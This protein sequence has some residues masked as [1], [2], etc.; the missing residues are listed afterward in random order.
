MQ[1]HGQTSTHAVSHVPT[2]FWVITY[3]MQDRRAGVVPEL[4]MD[5]DE[6]MERQTL[7]FQWLALAFEGILGIMDDALRIAS[8]LL[9]AIS[10]AHTPRALARAIATGLA[11]HIA[12]R[13]LE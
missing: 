6:V 11:P 8:R 3:A 10:E 1:S 9:D 12:F 5:G 4:T 2:H 13:R 7:I